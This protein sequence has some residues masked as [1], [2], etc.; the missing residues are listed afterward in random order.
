VVLTVVVHV[1]INETTDR[2]HVAR[3]AV[4]SVV[5]DILV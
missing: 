5:D 2:V 3:S 4:E 1:P